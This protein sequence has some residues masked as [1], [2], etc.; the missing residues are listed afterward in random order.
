MNEMFSEEEYLKVIRSY[1]RHYL[2]Y[3]GGRLMLVLKVMS[4]VLMRR[5]AADRI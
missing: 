5:E 2:M 4:Y 3:G 1:V